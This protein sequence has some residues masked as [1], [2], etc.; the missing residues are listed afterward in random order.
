MLTRPPA[1]RRA[2]AFL[3]EFERRDSLEYGVDRGQHDDC[4][5]AA[6]CMSKP[7]QGGDTTGFNVAVRRNAVIGNAVPSRKGHHLGIWRKEFELAPDRRKP[8]IITRNVKNGL[9]KRGVS[10][11]PAC[12]GGQEKSVIPL[13]HA[14]SHNGAFAACKL[15][16]YGRCGCL[17]G[18][19]LVEGLCFTRHYSLRSEL[20]QSNPAKANP[21]AHKKRG[22]PPRPK[23][24]RPAPRARESTDRYPHRAKK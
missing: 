23:P 3:V 22:R 24:R 21:R 13:G 16:E 2:A 15:V 19:F 5:L 12:Y 11:K 17:A 10:G 20:R 14:R 9:L 4:R 7:R 1:V 18:A 6:L 8:L